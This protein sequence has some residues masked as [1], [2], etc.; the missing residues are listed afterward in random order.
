MQ[1]LKACKR[2]L[3][4]PKSQL[5]SNKKF[6]SLLIKLSILGLLVW[7]VYQKFFFNENFDE[8]SEAFHEV[9]N[10][11]N[12]FY[13]I[14][15]M[16]LM[17]VNWG[18]EALKWKKLISKIE[19][20]SFW[21]SFKAI[22]SGITLAMFTPNRVGDFGGRVLLLEKASK[23]EGIAIT[24]IGSFSQIVASFGLGFL[25]WIG[26]SKVFRKVSNTE[27][28]LWVL[29]AMASMSFLFY[30]YFHLDILKRQ[31]SK[32]SFLKKYEKYYHSIVNYDS[33]E[34]WTILFLSALRYSV[35]SLQYW[36]LFK[37]FGIELELISGLILI[38]SIFFA[39]TIIPSI[40]IVELG[41]RA[42]IAVHFMSY[43]S[44]NPTAV[45][46]A[47]FVLWGIN[48]LVPAFVGLLVIFSIRNLLKTK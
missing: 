41:I 39:Q 28:A 3:M 13:L 45:L 22:C 35:F 20:I 32:I 1:V 34:L 14:L 42:N 19:K 11:R 23:L 15:S 27:F 24:L 2:P 46:S 38:F 10:S 25:G 40:A 6:W 17:P 37:T 8:I 5:K 48:L 36:F 44:T 16:L 12:N 31:M 18:I 7:S 9:L 33:K 29:L 21:Q 47:A 26:C 30:A 4:A 43:V